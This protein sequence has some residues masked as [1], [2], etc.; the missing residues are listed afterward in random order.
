MF[1][2][3]TQHGHLI[4]ALSHR[5]DINITMGRDKAASQIE[6]YAKNQTS[7]GVSE[8]GHFAACPESYQHLIPS[9]REKEYVCV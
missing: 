6:E 4:S 5:S 8:H 7:S 1:T 3:Q 9:C 2:K